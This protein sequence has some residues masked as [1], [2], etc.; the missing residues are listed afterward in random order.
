[1][2]Q[3]EVAYIADPD[4]DQEALNALDE[5]VKGWIEA[6]GGEVLEVDRWGKKRLAYP[7]QKRH[8]GFYIF[9]KAN[10]PPQAGISIERELGLSEQILR[11]MITV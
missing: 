4:L 5:K 2:R 11:S 3:Y 6:A 10:M 9:V 1:M 8:D 7:I